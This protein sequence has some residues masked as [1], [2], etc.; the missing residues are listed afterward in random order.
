MPAVNEVYVCERC[1]LKVQVLK[2][3]HCIPQCCGQEMQRKA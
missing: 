3:G 2:A 1:G